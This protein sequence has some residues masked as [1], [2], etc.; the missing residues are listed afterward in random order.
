[1]YGFF[2]IKH[3]RVLLEPSSPEQGR[4]N[5]TSQPEIVDKNSL[6][7]FS[8]NLLEKFLIAKNNI[9]A[10]EYL[11]QAKKDIWNLS[12]KTQEEYSKKIATLE[13]WLVIN[14]WVFNEKWVRNNLWKDT[15][16]Q[17]AESLWLKDFVIPVISPSEKQ[18]EVDE[19]KRNNPIQE[20]SKIQL[21]KCLEH[22]FNA[23]ENIP[24][25]IRML[26][27]KFWD[28][29]PEYIAVLE[30]LSMVVHDDQFKDNTWIIRS[31][32]NI[33][34]LLMGDKRGYDDLILAIENGLKESIITKKAVAIAYGKKNDWEK[35]FEAKSIEEEALKIQKDPSQ[36]NSQAV[37]R[38]LI[39][40]DWEKRIWSDAVKWLAFYLER[41][42][43]ASFLK[44]I[45]DSLLQKRK[46]R[47]T[48]VYM[49]IL[50]LD[51]FRKSF[52]SS[53]YKKMKSQFPNI[54]ESSF[55]GVIKGKSL[56]PSGLLNL[57]WIP[58]SS[59]SEANDSL[60]KIL[61]ILSNFKSETIIEKSISEKTLKESGIRSIW[62]ILKKYNIQNTIPAIKSL[63][64]EFHTLTDNEKLS[65]LAELRKNK[66]PEDDTV[67]KWLKSDDN[68]NKINAYTGTIKATQSIIQHW[69]DRALQDI[70]KWDIKTLNTIN[71]ASSTYIAT[72]K[73]NEQTTII[74]DSYSDILAKYKLNSGSLKNQW[75]A[76][77][78]YSKLLELHNKWNLSKREEEF[79]DILK[80]IITTHHVRTRAITEVS[81]NT[82]NSKYA[83][84]LLNEVNEWEQFTEKSLKIAEVFNRSS[85][86]S[87]EIPT[88]FSS[89]EK[90]ITYME[91][92]KTYWAIELWI[93]TNWDLDLW[94][95][96]LQ[97]YEFSTNWSSGICI[98]ESWVALIQNIPPSTVE[99]FLTQVQIMK[100]CWL[101]IFTQNIIDINKATSSGER[102]VN[103]LDD[104]FWPKEAMQLL[105]KSYKLI[106]N[107]ELT[108]NGN[109]IEVIK[110]FNFANPNKT[111]PSSWIYSALKWQWLINDDGTLRKFELKDCFKNLT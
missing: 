59:P 42:P 70:K 6:N 91:I 30:T 81:R 107:K 21:G 63:D 64:R 44:K 52:D 11:K 7:D 97:N 40:E 76:E 69:W 99:S 86:F 24:H 20:Y 23:R 12:P 9:E 13:Q 25:E 49:E 103:S 18:K 48:E 108:Q 66:I 111:N 96:G 8:K 34:S 2:F 31:W 36:M 71:A 32:S 77:D 22:P 50:N 92:G 46:S 83:I 80:W 65:I 110:A 93:K 29:I 78:L 95:P 105:E 85:Q 51:I 35:W 10:T 55:N 19:F 1:M 74:Q 62:D 47:L 90:R 68:I 27:N 17:V 87:A 109:L 100:A 58:S 57:K 79:F 33:K 72:E 101:D 84:K 88:D 3:P 60:R 45:P 14:R 15:L 5:K 16:K 94:L 28:Q 61:N 82:S 26:K 102:R 39:L 89:F 37:S 98:K 4:W 67:L 41:N 38:I 104:Y 43:D 56:N 53:L 75:I 106:F 73:M 54:E